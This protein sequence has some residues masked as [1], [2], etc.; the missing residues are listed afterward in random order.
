MSESPLS[1]FDHQK[2]QSTFLPT[3]KP[4]PRPSCQIVVIKP[5]RS[6]ENHIAFSD[7]LFCCLGNMIRSKQT[8]GW[9]AAAVSVFFIIFKILGFRRPLVFAV[10]M[11]LGLAVLPYQMRFVP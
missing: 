3:S 5:T 8:G 1:S 10:C 11:G 7:D 2:L 9:R 4:P 6:S